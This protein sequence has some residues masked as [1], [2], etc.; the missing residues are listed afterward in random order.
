[1]ANIQLDYTQ[2]SDL[3]AN[4]GVALEPL[5][6]TTWL[7]NQNFTIVN[8]NATALVICRQAGSIVTGTSGHNFIIWRFNIDDGDIVEEFGQLLWNQSAGVPMPLQGGVAAIDGLAAGAHTCRIEYYS[9][10]PVNFPTTSKSTAFLRP[11]AVVDGEG[12]SAP[13]I[14]EVEYLRLQVVEL[15]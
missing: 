12:N 7:T 1:M 4:P 14:A 10:Y 9:V 5:A 2:S 15:A 6:W 8:D 13:W 3:F 11:T